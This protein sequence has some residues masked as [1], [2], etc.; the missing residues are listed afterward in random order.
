MEKTNALRMLDDLNIHYS[1]YPYE[2]DESDLTGE[3]VAEKI[4]CSKDEIFKTLVAEGDKNGINVFCIP[5][6]QQ[7]DLKKAAKAS[8]NKKV[9]LIATKNLL[10]ITGYIRGGCSPIGMKKN[11][12]VFIDETITIFD[13]IYISAGKRGL[14]IKISTSVLINLTKAKL[15]DLSTDF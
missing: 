1:A 15:A 5:V 9:D 13:K 4:G 7:L 3:T 11:F 12:P 6:S 2:V 14:Q 10:N 8:G